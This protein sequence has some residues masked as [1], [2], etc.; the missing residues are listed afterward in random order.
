M[1][2]V[3]IK[4]LSD[5]QLVHREMS[6][7]RDLLGARFRLHTDQL[8]DTSSLKKMRRDIARLQTASRERERAQGLRKNTLRDRY[9]ATFTPTEGAE[10][11]PAASGGGFLQGIL[12][13][14]S[15]E[16]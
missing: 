5:E 6:I 7:E 11:A 16:D 8:E 2:Y 10:S 14:S 13:S 1:R 15:Q 12:D 3:E 4:D 9:R